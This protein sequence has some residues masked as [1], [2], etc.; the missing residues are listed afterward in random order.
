MTRWLFPDPPDLAVVTTR[1]IVEDG[2]WIAHVFNIAEVS[3]WEFHD[4]GPGEPREEDAMVVALHSMVERDPTLNEL[5]DLP[6]G[7]QAWRDG[8]TAPWKRGRIG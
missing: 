6:E 5:A 1:S 4:S 7:W 2:R 3:S 8:P